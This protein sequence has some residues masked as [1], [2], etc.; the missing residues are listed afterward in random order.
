MSQ[1][2]TTHYSTST[3][4]FVNDDPSVYIIPYVFVGSLEDL[5]DDKGMCRVSLTDIDMDEVGTQIL[6]PLIKRLQQIASTTQVSTITLVGQGF[7]ITLYH[8]LIT[9]IE[10]KFGLLFEIESTKENTK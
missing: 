8:A 5:T 1:T 2:P 6:R 7:S 4:L 3:V 10:T 9:Q